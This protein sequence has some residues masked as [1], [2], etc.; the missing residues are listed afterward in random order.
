MYFITNQKALQLEEMTTATTQQL[1]YNTRRQERILIQ[2][3]KRKW[4]LSNAQKKKTNKQTNK[5]K[6]ISEAD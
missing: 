1:R 4:L 6:L 5:N 2:N 3:R